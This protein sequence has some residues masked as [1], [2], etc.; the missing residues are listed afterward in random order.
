M[1]LKASQPKMEYVTDVLLQ[2]LTGE[3]SAFNSAVLKHRG[4]RVVEM[5]LAQL[6]SNSPQEWLS[7]SRKTPLRFTEYGE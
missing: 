4:N 1:S 7:V 6:L 5:V 2:T 3:W